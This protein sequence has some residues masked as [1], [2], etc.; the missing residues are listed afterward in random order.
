[1]GIPAAV[2]TGLG[3]VSGDWPGLSG[4]HSPEVTTA[5]AGVE[6]RGDALPGAHPAA[7]R[8]LAP[9]PGRPPALAARPGLHPHLAPPWPGVL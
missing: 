2:Q 6:H 5:G 3:L 9:V 7:P 8:L 4:A 1:M